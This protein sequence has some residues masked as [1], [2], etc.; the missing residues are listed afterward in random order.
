MK[1]ELRLRDLYF[2]ALTGVI[3]SGWIY[4]S[5]Y[6]A[7]VV[8]PA[9]IISWII[10]G[11]FILIIALTWAEVSSRYP[12]AG[13]GGRYYKYSH[14][15]L[16]NAIGGFSA[17]LPAIATPAIESIAIVGVIQAALATTKYKVDFIN[18][19]GLPTAI[20]TLL[21]VLI[22]L[23]FFYINYI[24]V[25][26]VANVNSIVS[27]IKL[28]ILIILI[29]AVIV[30]GLA[31][32]LGT[33]FSIPSFAPFGVLP[34]FTAIPATGIIFAYLGFRQPIEMAGEAKN[35]TKDLPKAIILLVITVIIIYTLLEVAF[36]GGL[37]WNN[38][39]VGTSG[40]MAG[41]WSSLTTALSTSAFPLFDISL[42]LGLFWLAGLVAIGGV[43]G[44]AADTNQYYA[45]TARILFGMGREG[46]FS[47]K[48]GKMGEVDA[49]H[50]VPVLGLLITLAVTI[51]LL[52]LGFGG[53]LVS[54]VGGLW[55]A[56]TSIIT[57]TLVF[58][59]TASSITLPIF[60]RYYLT[61]KKG[62]Y[63]LKGYQI[64]S[65]IGFIISS[66]L[67]YWGAGSLF[68]STDPYGGY[69]LIILMLAGGLLYLTTKE[70][71]N[72]EHIKEDVKASLWMIFYLALFIPILYLGEYKT[73]Y[74]KAPYDW[75]VVIVYAIVFYIWA[76]LSALP[77]DRIKKELDAAISAI[78][79]E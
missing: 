20:G 36:I 40:V 75:F 43:I 24:G 64:I 74:I 56:L 71:R 41:E 42:G 3:G 54:S 12:V 76:Q 38:S 57:T 1:K 58:A 26:R 2:A 59:Y 17:I 13:A 70:S 6:A 4:G 25:R 31:A 11:I 37:K 50:H 27:Y 78:E 51:V 55:V 29:I 5:Y 67:V 22:S 73:N 62:S 30:A 16:A 28:P 44:P 79:V 61:P 23:F 49:K 72:N 18:S 7:G 21:A 60:R 66:L 39:A 69:I 68:T 10:G 14:G 9:S 15:S 32:G 34:I 53:Y 52:L 35:P 33:N 46:Y 65:P 8:G 19:L 77:A 45:S 48:S 63:T 47:G